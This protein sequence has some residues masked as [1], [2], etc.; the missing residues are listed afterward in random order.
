MRMPVGFLKTEPI[1]EAASPLELHA[2][3]HVEGR[4]FC[5][6]RK[7][8]TPAPFGLNIDYSLSLDFDSNGYLVAADALLPS[9]EFYETV[10]VALPSSPSMA[11]MRLANIPTGEDE[12]FDCPISVNAS[13]DG[14]RAQVFVQDLMPGAVWF[15]LGRSFL[16]ALNEGR[17][18]SVVFDSSAL[19]IPAVKARRSRLR[20][21]PS[22][23]RS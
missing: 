14:L 5:A 4:I 11:T 21:S 3:Y 12:E 15:S 2:V 8:F 19:R 10:H 1:G 7:T 18:A 13:P 16:F 9:R 6:D 22:W 17:L 20:T 23:R